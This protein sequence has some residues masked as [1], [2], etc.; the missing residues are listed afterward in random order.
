M[1]RRAWKPIAG[2]V[3]LGTPAFVYYR[4]YYVQQTFELP[5]RVRNAEGKA[6][7]RSHT[8]QLLPLKTLEERI[9]E[10]ATYRTHT[11]SD[12]LVWNFTTAA[13]ASND[14]LEDANATQIITRDPSD[15]SAPGDY[16]FFAVM[17]G[18]SGFHTSQLLSRILIKAVT[19]RLSSLNSPTSQSKTG[20]LESMKSLFRTTSTSDRKSPMDADPNLV[21]FAIKEAFTNLD[22]ELINAPLRVLANGLDEAAKKSKVIPDL[23]Q[24]PLAL[25]TMLPAV[26]G[27]CAIMAMIDTAHR[28]LYVACTGDSRAVAGIWEDTGDGSGQWRVEVLSEDQTGRN[29]SEHERIKSEH[30]KEEEDY[31]IRDGR[32]LGGLEP[33]RAFGDARYKWPRIVQETLNQAFMAGNNKPLRPPPSLFK[34]PPYVTATPEVTH[35]ELSFTSTGNTP[36]SKG[37]R[38][39]VLATDGLWDQLSNEEVVGLVGGY[40]SGLKGAIPKSELPTLIPTVTGAAGVDGKRQRTKKSGEG[41]WSFTDDNLSAHL[42]R[43]AFGGG[44]EMTL[45]KMLSIPAPYSRRYRDDV[46]VTIVWWEEGR[47]HEAK[48]STERIRP[49]L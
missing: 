14:P 37:I 46:T 6:E 3:A 13:L 43:N 21:S 23:S 40:F 31:V 27:S 19:V 48:L 30:P 38:F 10:N 44:D 1:L 42:I 22:Q 49:K 7:M 35:R 15:P 20:I 28:N 47:A 32:V 33:T 18:H 11:S 12:D 41:L 45:R 24:H 2:A 26:S 9:R 39:L 29:P 17:D 36:S 5:I 4:T 25:T 34:T 16:L 8:F